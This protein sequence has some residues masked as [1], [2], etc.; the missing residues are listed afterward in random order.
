[1]EV[2][3][4]NSATTRVTADV[5]EL[6]TH[7]MTEDYGNPSSMHNK[8][9]EA[10]KYLRE[11][12]E[13]FAGILKVSEKE[14][15][16]TSGG[17]EADNMAIIGGALAN[18]RAGNH[19]IT[20]EIEHPAVS[21]CFD[22][23][24]KNGF[25]VTRLKVDRNGQISLS[26]LSDAIRDD[27]ILVS[28]MYVNNEIG[29]CEPIAEAGRI[30]KERNRNIFFHV[31][32]VQAFGKYRIYPARLGIDALS[33]SSHKIH[34]PKGVGV[35]YIRDKAKI[36]QTVFGGGQ[37]RGMRSG[38]ENVPGIA[39]M[40]LAAKNCYA[41][42]DE[43]IRKLYELKKFFVDGIR[44]IPDTIV[45]GL[46]DENSAPHVVSVSFD[47]ISKSEV[48]LHALE[49]RGIYVSSGSACASN[50]PAI[51]ATLRAIGVERNLL[52]STIRFSFSRFT[53]KEELEYVLSALGEILPQLKK[54]RPR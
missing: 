17:T 13:T 6:M 5:A 49:E 15:F 29:A 45:N 43:D 33:I 1:M 32:A 23:L 30:I 44:L 3:L 54:Y 20:T 53:T 12:R 47:G 48:L 51:S 21:E 50:K 14:I 10:E 40:A 41:D 27:T 42:F 38:T 4:D 26:E 37:Q 24:E 36:T 39:G 34:G 22:F 2:Y 25:S 52:T 11:A 46:T 28:V 31:D 9:F 19:I 7:I 35:L 18:R 16:F 8:G